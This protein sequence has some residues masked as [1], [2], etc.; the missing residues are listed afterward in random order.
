[1]EINFR[2]IN[3]ERL[4]DY[5]MIASLSDE[6]K[7]LVVDV[8]LEAYIDGLSDGVNIEA[9][10]EEDSTST[11]ISELATEINFKL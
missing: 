2:K 9:G 4:I 10:L 11:F 3:M 1:M 7:K 8:A 6:M 5:K